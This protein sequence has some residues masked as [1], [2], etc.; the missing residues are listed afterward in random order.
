MLRFVAIACLMVGVVLLYGQW[1]PTQAR[2]LSTPYLGSMLGLITLPGAT[3][4]ARRMERRVRR[5]L[6]GRVI[7]G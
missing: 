3:L 6:P 7:A 2:Q 1:D 4:A 5:S